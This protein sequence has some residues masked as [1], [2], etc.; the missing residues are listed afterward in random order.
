MKLNL[1]DLQR[2]VGFLASTLAGLTPKT[3]Q[4][5]KTIQNIADI[6]RA[7]AQQHEIPVEDAI[8]AGCSALMGLLS[9]L[10]QC[11]HWEKLSEVLTYDPLLIPAQD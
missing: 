6:F 11:P 8:I 7:E 3:I 5:E 1:D 2:R 4:R 9:V 10:P